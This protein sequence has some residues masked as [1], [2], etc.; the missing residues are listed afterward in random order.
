MRTHIIGCEH[1]IYPQTS[2]RYEPLH[3]R[4]NL[5]FLCVVHYYSLS[6]MA[7]SGKQTDKYDKSKQKLR[8]LSEPLKIG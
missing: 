5:D 4:G 8:R 7:T 2:L 6:K 3:K 1:I